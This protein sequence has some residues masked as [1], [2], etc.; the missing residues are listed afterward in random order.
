MKNKKLTFLIIEDTLRKIINFQTLPTY[1][2]FT[3]VFLKE[4]KRYVSIDLKLLM[5]IFSH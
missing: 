1:C 3:L 5:L 2:V 4:S